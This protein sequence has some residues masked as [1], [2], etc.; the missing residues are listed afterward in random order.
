MVS[1]ILNVNNTWV[2]VTSCT[3]K[4]LYLWV[5]NLCYALSRGFVGPTAGLVT[6][7]KRKVSS[8]CQE[9]N[10]DSVSVLEPNLYTH[11]VHL[12]IHVGILGAWTATRS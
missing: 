8:S 11:F 6:L 7:E 5:E 10:H 4:L 9:S 2:L 1:C 3:T 12:L